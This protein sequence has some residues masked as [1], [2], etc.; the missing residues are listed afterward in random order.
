MPDISYQLYGSR[1]WALDETFSMLAQAGYKEVEGYGGIYSNVDALERAMGETGLLMTTGHIGLSDL[2]SDPA[3]AVALAKG[4]GITGMFAPHI[5]ADERPNDIAGWEYFGQKL[6]EA[7]KPI[8]DAGISFGWHNHDFEMVDLG[9]GV[10]PFDLIA[11]ASPDLALEL[12]IGWV[13]RAGR[14]A[15]PLIEKYGT[16]ITAVHVK[17][18]AP[19]GECVDEDGWAD[20]G[21]GVVDWAPIHAALQKAG[22]DRYV[23]EHDNPNDHQRFASRS[24]AAVKSF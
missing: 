6:A 22:I 7:G 5:D 16:Q 10:M 4:L 8:Q 17:D 13:I 2:E 18:I 15:V 12:D 23:V 14:D 21:H 3:G 9:G 19:A 1:N 11:Q 24:L 20:V